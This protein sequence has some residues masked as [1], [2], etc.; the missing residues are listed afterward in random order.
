MPKP[1][2]RIMQIDLLVDPDGP[3]ALFHYWLAPSRHYRCPI[4]VDAGRKR[5]F[6]QRVSKAQEMLCQT[7]EEEECDCGADLRGVVGS[8]HHQACEDWAPF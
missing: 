2:E 4:Y 8:H 1:H 3:Q 6:I 5:R 7:M